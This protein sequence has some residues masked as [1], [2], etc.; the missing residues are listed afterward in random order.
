MGQAKEGIEIE[1]VEW[2]NEARRNRRVVSSE[3]EAARGWTVW[4]D[5]RWAGEV[6]KEL[7]GLVLKVQRSARNTKRRQQQLAFHMSGR[8][9]PRASSLRTSD[10]LRTLYDEDE[11]GPVSSI[12]SLLHFCCG[13]RIAP[14]FSIR[15]LP[16]RACLSLWGTS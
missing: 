13:T 11:R 8:P 10:C 4:E 5:V 7:S 16:V 9:E 2:G 3:G 1:V 12:R 6:G 15:L 14:L